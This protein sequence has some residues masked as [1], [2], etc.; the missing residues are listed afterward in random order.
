MLK[1]KLKR[2]NTPNIY[3]YLFFFYVFYKHMLV[4]PNFHGD[5]NVRT[6]LFVISG[7]LVPFFYYTRIFSF[8]FLH[9]LLQ[10]DYNSRNFPQWP[11]PCV[12]Q[13]N[14]SCIRWSHTQQRLVQ[15]PPFFGLHSSVHSMFSA[16]AE[17]ISQICQRK[18]AHTRELRT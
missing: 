15:K 13:K 3:I 4:I 12:F 10:F 16:Q 6:Q 2:C 7:Y 18:S 11:P 14:H 17:E 8:Q 1:L 5:I 9:E